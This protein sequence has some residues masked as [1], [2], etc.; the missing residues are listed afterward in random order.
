[1]SKVAGGEASMESTPRFPSSED[2]SIMN[3]NIKISSGD[4]RH[5]TCAKLKKLLL[6]LSFVAAL[7]VVLLVVASKVRA[8]CFENL[9]EH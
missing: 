8:E 1:M 2:G 3:L 7:S 4:G 6:F 9:T 5:L